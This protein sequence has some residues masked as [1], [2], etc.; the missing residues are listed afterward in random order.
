MAYTDET[1]IGGLSQSYIAGGQEPCT[2]PRKG[3]RLYMTS[4]LMF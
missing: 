1:V 3:N 4:V 2:T